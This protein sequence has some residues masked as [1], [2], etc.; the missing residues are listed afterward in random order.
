MT[1]Y[2][3]IEKQ[4]KLIDTMIA[5]RGVCRKQ[6]MI[7]DIV[8]TI[9]IGLVMAV[10]FIGYWFSDTSYDYINSNNSVEGSQDVQMGGDK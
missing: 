7:K 8:I 10:F 6:N 3:F 4:S 9:T 1:E 5:D 2:E